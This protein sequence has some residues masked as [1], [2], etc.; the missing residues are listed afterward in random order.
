MGDVDTP[1][2]NG[3]RTLGRTNDET[4]RGIALYPVLVSL[5]MDLGR[6]SFCAKVKSPRGRRMANIQPRTVYNYCI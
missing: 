2:E 3:N 4:A 6:V 5:G 1:Y